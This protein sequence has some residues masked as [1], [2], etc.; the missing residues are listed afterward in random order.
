MQQMRVIKP[1]RRSVSGLYSYNGL[2]IPYESTLERDFVIFQTFRTNV[3][4]VI[5]QPVVI[6][7]KK[8]GRAYKYTP[9]YFVHLDDGAEYRQE[10]IKHLIVEVKPRSEW[11][12]NWRDW[13][14]K[15][16]AAISYSDEH[17]FRFKIYDESRIHH[18]GLENVKYVLRFRKTACC[19]HDIQVI[20]NQ[21]EMMGNTTIEY[22][23][24][25]FF[26]GGIYQ[27]QG[28]RT[29][30]HLLGTKRLGFDFWEELDEKTEVWHV[31]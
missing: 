28:K 29:I 21:V 14:D 9:D 8:N 3:L 26:K 24:E 27:P 30:L 4:E 11:K 23:L 5:A 1:T 18:K 16:K 2:S 10:L 13:S 15:W 22:L 6:P 25:K 17:N 19:E 12:K 20:L 7:F 31:Q